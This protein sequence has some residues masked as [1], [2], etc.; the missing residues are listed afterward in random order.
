M[1]RPSPDYPEEIAQAIE[2]ALMDYPRLIRNA[3]ANK[4]ALT[5]LRAPEQIVGEM[6]KALRAVKS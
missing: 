6:V 5:R 4:R 1:N 2:Q 3:L